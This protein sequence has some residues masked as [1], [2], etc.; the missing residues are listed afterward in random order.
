MNEPSREWTDS[1]ADNIYIESKTSRENWGIHLRIA[2]QQLLD[3]DSEAR[4]WFLGWSQGSKI[5][6][7]SEKVD[8]KEF[9]E[10]KHNNNNRNE[11][12]SAASACAPNT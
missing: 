1:K 11:D 9:G 8:R 10:K 4:L 6:P 2:A 5:N 3:K 12:K 7:W